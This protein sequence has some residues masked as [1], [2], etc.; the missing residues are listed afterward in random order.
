MSKQPTFNEVLGGV[1]LRLYEF[2][3][4]EEVDAWLEEPHPQLDGVP[5][6]EAIRRGRAEDVHQ[7]IDGLE[8]LPYL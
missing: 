5:A 4:T 2:Y 6:I 3:S 7:I 1:V 8:A